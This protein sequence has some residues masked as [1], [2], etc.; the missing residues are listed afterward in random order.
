[1]VSVVAFVF[2][3]DGPE[4]SCVLVCKCHHSLLPPT[5]LAQP[6]HPLRDRI[7]IVD[8]CEQGS[9]GPLYQQGRK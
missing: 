6:L 3:H 1:M 2:G 5:T 9:L 8:P 7:D 4:Y